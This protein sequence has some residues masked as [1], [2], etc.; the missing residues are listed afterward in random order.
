MTTYETGK[1]D[2]EEDFIFVPRS[3]Y[4]LRRSKSGWK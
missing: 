4:C 1:I 2:L 3:K